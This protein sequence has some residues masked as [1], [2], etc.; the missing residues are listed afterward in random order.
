MFIE[1]FVFDVW[2]IVIDDGV[3][4]IEYRYKVLEYLF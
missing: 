2:D 1:N 4:I 3:I